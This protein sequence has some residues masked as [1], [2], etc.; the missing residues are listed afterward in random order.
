MSRAWLAFCVV[1]IIGFT[2]FLFVDGDD[3]LRSDDPYLVGF[4]VGIAASC[5]AVIYTALEG[6]ARR[7]GHIRLGR[8]AYALLLAAWCLSLWAA[9]FAGGEAAD[10]L[11]YAASASL[12]VGLVTFLLC[13]FDAPRVLTIAMS[14]FGILLL[15]MYCVVS[16][17]M[18][19][20]FY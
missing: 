3:P 6:I 2:L 4:T 12:V 18:E 9:S 11:A 8:S 13:R 19:L 10:V 15:A 5:L 17:R 1:A 7:I 20:R 16:V 14:C